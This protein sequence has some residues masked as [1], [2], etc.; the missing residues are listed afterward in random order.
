VQKDVTINGGVL[1]LKGQK[2]GEPLEGRLLIYA[3]FYDDNE[4][5]IEHTIIINGNGDSNFVGTMFAPTA[6]ITLDGKANDED[7]TWNGQVV[8]DTIKVTGTVN[9]NLVYDD[10]VGID[11]V[12]QPTISMQQ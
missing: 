6:D 7:T 3:P 4:N 10:E 12:H 9:W 11:V 5:I 1:K 8:G 2:F